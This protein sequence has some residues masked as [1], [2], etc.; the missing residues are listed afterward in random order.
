MQGYKLT[1]FT[2]QDRTVHGQSIA[3]WLI[4]QAKNIGIRGASLTTATEGFGHD[5]KLHSA[6]FFE[7]AEQ[8]LQVTM[9]VTADEAEQMFALLKKEGL[10]I[11]YTQAAIEFGMSAER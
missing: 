5:K 6:H 7:L 3:S 4:L 8:P 1:F 11:F 10:N 9:A 2:Q